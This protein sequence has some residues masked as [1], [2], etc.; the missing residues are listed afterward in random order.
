MQQVDMIELFFINVIGYGLYHIALA[1]YEFM[2]EWIR[3][4]D[5]RDYFNK[6]GK[7]SRFAVK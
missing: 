3:M 2:E 7:V 4:S 1:E 5:V 6:C